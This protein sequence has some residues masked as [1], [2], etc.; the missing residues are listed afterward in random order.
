MSL[1]NWD[2]NNW[3]SSK[4][5]INNFNDFLSKQFKINKKSQILDIGCGRGKIVGNLYSKFHLHDKPI[6]VDIESHEDK[7]KRLNFKKTDALNFLKKNKKKFDLIIIKQSIHFFSF[8]Q[9]K[10]LLQFSKKNL[11]INGKILIFTL[12]TKKNEIPVFLLMKKKL[13]KSLK[14]DK[15]ILTFIKKMY[16]SLILKKYT[17][18]VKVKREKYIRMVKNRY[19]SI[20]LDLQTNEISRGANEIRSNFKS[21]IRFND[22][23]ICAVLKK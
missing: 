21:Q 15:K 3:L 16:P 22:K 8:H 23:L 9:I 10:T 4:K 5:Y 19:I 1:K 6:G 17:Y 18:K 14:R 13:E 11:K 7:D 12:E 2:N 20:L